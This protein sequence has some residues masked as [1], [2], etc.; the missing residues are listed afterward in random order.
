MPGLSV[1]YLGV[2]RKM[3]ARVGKSS[4]VENITNLRA[5]SAVRHSQFFAIW[6]QVL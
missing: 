5:L 6:I 1:P 3:S 2:S 4:F